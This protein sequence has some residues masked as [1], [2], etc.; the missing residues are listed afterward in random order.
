MTVGVVVS[1][2]RGNTGQAASVGHLTD[3]QKYKNEH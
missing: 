1:H 3:N 2:Q